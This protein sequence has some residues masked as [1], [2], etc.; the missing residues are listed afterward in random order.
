MSSDTP[1]PPLGPTE[2]DSLAERRRGGSPPDRPPNPARSTERGSDLRDTVAMSTIDLRSVA[3]GDATIRLQPDSAPDPTVPVEID[4]VI[5]GRY[6]LE[7]EL[8][9]GGFGVV[10]LAYDREL[11]RQVA[12]KVARRSS[13]LSIDSLL[14][15]GRKVAQLDHPNIVPVYDCGHLDETTVF[16]VSKHVD[17]GS[18]ASQLALRRLPIDEVVAIAAQ[19]ADALAHAH[20]KGYIHRDLKPSNILLDVR[21]NAYVADFGLALRTTDRSD[22]HCVE[23]SLRYMSP[24]QAGGKSRLVDW[25][26]DVYSFGVILYEMLTGRLP[27]P[28]WSRGDP[29]SMEIIEI[30]EPV[31][32]SRLVPEISPCLERICLKAMAIHPEDRFASAW[33]LAE[34]LRPCRAGS[35]RRRG[36]GRAWLRQGVSVVFLVLMAAVLVQAFGPRIGAL[37]GRGA[38]AGPAPG[39]GRTLPGWPPVVASPLDRE[40]AEWAIGR[41]GA[42]DFVTHPATITRLEQLPEVMRPL[43]TVELIGIK[44][45]GGEEVAAVCALPGLTFLHLG[46]TGLRDEDLVLISRIAGLR[47][48]WVG[49]N[50]LSD[51]GIMQ[52]GRLKHLRHL[53]LERTYL[54]N[55]G[56]PAIGRAEGLEFLNLSGTQVTDGGLMPLQALP[57]LRQLWLNQTMLTDASVDDLLELPGLTRLELRD[58]AITAEG[59]GRLRSGLPGCVIVHDAGSDDRPGGLRGMGESRSGE[60]AAF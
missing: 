12:I 47:M 35:A 58:T 26:T 59:V 33:E 45:M 7:R 53:D 32:P 51:R 15:E 52:L 6:C 14:E 34:E 16:I 20:E 18:L 3:R 40:V 36:R 60:D 10:M 39:A 31:A 22:R 21:N 9:R 48:L 55:A 13:D 8:G 27:F 57:R 30:E 49:W 11:H 50:D 5:E 19:V 2:R 17:G 46:D 56:V 1:N 23:G 38:G 28:V 4:R 44:P 24:E 43:R 29:R 42:V 54:T 41:G 37:L 25:R